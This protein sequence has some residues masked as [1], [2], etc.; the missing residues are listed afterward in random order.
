MDTDNFWVRVKALIKAHK[1]TQKQFARITGFSPNTVR[2]WIYHD[3]VP[4]LSAA[5]VIAFTL[6]VSLE[7]LLGGKDKDIAKAR[8]KELE[9][10]KS[11]AR[12]LKMIDKIQKELVLM[13]PLE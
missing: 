13:R 7:Y 3:R 1:M 10:R 9:M 6:G 8:I 5:Y 4:E 12:I 2:G 11:A